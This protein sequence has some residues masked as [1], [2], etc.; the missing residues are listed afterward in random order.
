[1]TTSRPAEA[2]PQII[3]HRSEGPYYAMVRQCLLS[4]NFPFIEAGFLA[5]VGDKKILEST[6]LAIAVMDGERDGIDFLRSVMRYDPLIQRMLMTAQIDTGLLEQAVNKAHINY[7]LPLP[8]DKE[9][10]FLYINKAHK[11]Y[12][13]LIRPFTRFKMLSR[14]THD[15]FYDKE[16]YKK[17][18]VSDALTGLLNRRSFSTFLASLYEPDPDRQRQPAFAMAMLDLDHFKNINDTFGHLAG[19]Q[20]LRT[21]GRL[22]HDNL[23]EGLDQAFRY[24]GEEFVIISMNASVA[25]MEHAIDRLLKRVREIRVTYEGREM[26]FTFSAGVVHSSMADSMDKIIRLADEMLY[27]AKETGRNRSCTYATNI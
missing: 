23:R 27:K 14:L 25:D 21:F 10:L 26:A 4:W 15:L 9:S 1:M 8:P 19:D 7:Y 13:D 6:Q 2:Y 24:G 17:E 3:L 20:V 18:A 12:D 5:G 22:L 16:K 11:R